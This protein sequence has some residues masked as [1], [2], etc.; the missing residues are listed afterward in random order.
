MTLSHDDSTINI[1]LNYYY[2]YYITNTFWSAFHVRVYF[3]AWQIYYCHSQSAFEPVVGRGHVGRLSCDWPSL[4]PVCALIG[5][6]QEL[7]VEKCICYIGF[8]SGPAAA[9]RSVCECIGSGLFL[10]GKLVQ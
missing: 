5:Q 7:I 2:Y 8:H 10:P 3:P 4:E 6:A 9:L 1:D